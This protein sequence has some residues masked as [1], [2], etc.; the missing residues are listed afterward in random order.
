MQSSLKGKD[1]LLSVLNNHTYATFIV[2]GFDNQE[3]NLT[4]VKTDFQVSKLKFYSCNF[5]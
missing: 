1:I 4:F 5:A 2:N 3:R